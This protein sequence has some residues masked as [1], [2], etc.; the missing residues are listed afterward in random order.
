L[1]TIFARGPCSA[2]G[3]KRRLRGDIPRF[4]ELIKKFGTTAN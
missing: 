2:R 3:G 4:A 1:Q